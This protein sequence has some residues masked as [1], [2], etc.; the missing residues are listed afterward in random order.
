VGMFESDIGQKPLMSYPAITPG[1]DQLNTLYGFFHATQ[2]TQNVCRR[3]CA[4][5]R[6]HAL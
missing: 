2:G 5:Q 6:R 3:I 1:R 4:T